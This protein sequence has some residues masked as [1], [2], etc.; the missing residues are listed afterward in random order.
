V[1]DEEGVLG[2]ARAAVAQRVVTSRIRRTWVLMVFLGGLVL[3]AAGLFGRRQA[4]RLARPVVDLAASLGRLGDGDFSVHA[5]P[6]GIPEIDAAGQAL[7]ATADRLGHLLQRERSFSADASHQ[8]STPLTGLRVTLEGALV[9]PGAD[10][11]ATVEGAIAEVD[12][13]QATVAH[14]LDLARD[15][16]ASTSASDV[17]EWLAEV[18][19]VWHGQLAAR[20]RPLRIEVGPFL[21]RVRFSKAAGEQILQVLIDNAF[22]HGAGAVTVRA[23][24]AGAGVVVEVEDEGPGVGGEAWGIGL[25]LAH[26]LADA[27]GGRLILRRAAPSPVFALVLPGAPQ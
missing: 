4:R 18:E 19:R 23:T 11:H 17:A 6:S 25:G 20:G 16:V 21:P 22:R 3:L 10:L 15:R 5:E 24:P 9:T 26:R 14:L 1:A 12:R 8:L 2:A 7:T 13:L 27:D